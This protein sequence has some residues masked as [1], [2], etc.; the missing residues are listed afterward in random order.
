M[1]YLYSAE[2]KEIINIV[3]IRIYFTVLFIDLV[4]LNE[5]C[6]NRFI[7]RRDDQRRG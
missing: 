3:A 5:L 2:F 4:K 1:I 6:L 7:E